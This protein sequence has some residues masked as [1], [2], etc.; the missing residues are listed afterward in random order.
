MKA[1]SVHCGEGIYPRW[2]AKRPQNAAAGVSGRLNDSRGCCA[3]NGDKSPR[4]KSLLVTGEFPLQPLGKSLDP[5]PSNVRRQATSPCASAYDCARIRRLVH[6]GSH[7]YFGS[8]H[9]PSVI[10][11][12]RSVFQGAHCS[13]QSGIPFSCTRW[14]LCAGRP[15]ARRF[16]GSPVD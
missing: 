10:G 11:F 12:S 14:W 4:H 7:R 15:R 2:G 6:L 13:I 3:A 1:Y 9:C 5:R 8:R 16:L